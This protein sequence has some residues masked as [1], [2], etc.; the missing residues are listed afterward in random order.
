MLVVSA[1]AYNGLKILT[2][3]AFCRSQVASFFAPSVSCILDSVKNQLS[4]SQ[5]PIH[6]RLFPFENIIE[7]TPVTLSS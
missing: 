7:R 5:K 1:F 4:I 2:N 3:D 6:V